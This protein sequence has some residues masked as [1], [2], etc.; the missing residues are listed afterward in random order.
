[1]KKLLLLGLILAG[2]NS[3]EAQTVYEA[4]SYSAQHYIYLPYSACLVSSVQIGANHWLS[5]VQNYGTRKIKDIAANGARR[6]EIVLISLQN[7]QA[8]WLDPEEEYI[9]FSGNEFYRIVKDS[10]VT[11]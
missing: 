9:T 10:Y 5:C 2:V 6:G 7:E 8:Q 11:K 4:T 1:M 3:A